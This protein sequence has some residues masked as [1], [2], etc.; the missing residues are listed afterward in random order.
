MES[1][2]KVYKSRPANL[3]QLAE[4]I[5]LLEAE[6]AA[7]EKTEAR[8]EP[9]DPH[10]NPSPSPMPLIPTLALA[11]TLALTITLALTLTLEPARRG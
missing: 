7:F 11:L 1:V 6:E 9:Y 3:D 4:H 8:S 10:P 2:Q 5:H